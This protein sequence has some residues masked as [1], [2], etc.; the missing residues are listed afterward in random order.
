TATIFKCFGD[1]VTHLQAASSVIAGSNTVRMH[2]LLLPMLI[3]FFPG[4][5][6][7]ARFLAATGV[8]CERS[9]NTFTLLISYGRVCTVPSSTSA[10]KPGRGE[11]ALLSVRCGRLDHLLRRTLFLPIGHVGK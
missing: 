4:F 3:L 7:C 5:R 9:K 10:C 6:A 8:A 2:R 1:P 11:H